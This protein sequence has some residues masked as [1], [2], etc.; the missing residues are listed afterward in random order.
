MI[1]KLI[2]LHNRDSFINIT[3]FLIP[4]SSVSKTKVDASLT[5]VLVD[6]PLIADASL[7]LDLLECSS[8]PGTDSNAVKSY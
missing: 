1:N 2:K 6:I 5:Y 3:Y 4:F 8:F 7:R